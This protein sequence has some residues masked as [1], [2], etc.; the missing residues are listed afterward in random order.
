MRIWNPPSNGHILKLDGKTIAKGGEV[1]YA[2]YQHPWIITVDD[3]PEVKPVV[4][5][6]PI[7]SEQLDSIFAPG[8]FIPPGMSI[9]EELPEAVEPVAV[10]APKKRGP[11]PKQK[12]V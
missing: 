5:P 11:K 6:I 3:E 9:E 2:L 7:V 10:P 4:K 8:V 1:P 12:G